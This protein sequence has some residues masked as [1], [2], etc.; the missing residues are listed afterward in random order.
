MSSFLNGSVFFTLHIIIM[1]VILY[2][3]EVDDSASMTSLISQVTPGQ[4]V[5]LGRENVKPTPY[6]DHSI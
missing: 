1:E 5:W 2:S 6:T 4:E 3:Y